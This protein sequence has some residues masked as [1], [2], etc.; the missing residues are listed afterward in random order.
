M[1][2]RA[3]TGQRTMHSPQER[4]IESIKRCIAKGSYFHGVAAVGH[5]DGPDAGYLL[6]GAH[7]PGAENAPVPV[8]VKEGI[9]GINRDVTWYPC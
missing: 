4:Q 8:N 2:V 3:P 7:T 9:A 5:V 1:G 6:A